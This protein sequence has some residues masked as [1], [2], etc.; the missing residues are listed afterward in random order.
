ML[1]FW[2]FQEVDITFG[3]TK[4]DHLIKLVTASYVWCK[5]MSF[6]VTLSVCEV[7]L[8][9]CRNILSPTLLTPEFYAPLMNFGWN[10]NT[11]EVESGNFFSSFFSYIVYL[12]VFQRIFSPSLSWVLL[13]T[14][15]FLIQCGLIHC[16][17]FP[18]IKAQIV[19]NLAMKAPSGWLLCSSMHLTTSFLPG[20]SCPRLI[21]TLLN[22]TWS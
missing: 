6:L 21:F 5:G 20:T 3:D 9:P 11:M 8:W 7:E 22:L 2:R 13:W 10:V 18:C 17:N 16:H 14:Q 15:D 19:P 1:T 12:S 4:F